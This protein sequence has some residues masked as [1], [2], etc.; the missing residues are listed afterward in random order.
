MAGGKDAA[1]LI[2]LDPGAYTA[3]I[4][5]VGDT[6]G[7]ALAELYELD[8]TT[9]NQLTNISSRA[10]VGTGSAIMISGLIVKGDLPQR[11]LIRGVGPGLT[12]FSVAGVL[13]NPKIEVVNAA[14][15]VV[16]A[17]DDWSVNDSLAETTTVSAALNV[18][19]LANSSKDAA[20]VVSL[21]PGAY[22]VL[23]K[24]VND[25]TGVAL[26]EAYLVP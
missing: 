1:V 12:Q 11:F 3:V 24:G 16:A 6:T 15:T 19:P 4:S 5:G 7:V 10:Y 17:N 26:V 18:F 23:V 2:N 22:T 8:S 13:A 21:N 9:S 25:T 20:M 14:G